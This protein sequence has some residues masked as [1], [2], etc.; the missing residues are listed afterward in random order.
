MSGDAAV[1]EGDMPTEGL[2][3]VA[4]LKLGVG[5]IMLALVDMGGLVASAEELLADMGPDDACCMGGEPNIIEG[6]NAA[7]VPNIML[8]GPLAKGGSKGR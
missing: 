3:S 4:L 8:P 5:I 7:F 6:G 2:G 1:D